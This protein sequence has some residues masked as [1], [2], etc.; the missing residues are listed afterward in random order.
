[1]RPR[2][3]MLRMKAR[4][5]TLENKVSELEKNLVQKDKALKSKD[6]IIK[7]L[8][9]RITQKLIEKYGRRSE[10]FDPNQYGLFDEPLEIED[11]KAKAELPETITVPAYE[12]KKNC[13]RKPLPKHL[14]REIIKHDLTEA[15]KVCACGTDLHCIGH[16]KAEQLE[17]IP[18]RYKVL[19]HITYKYACRSCDEGVK[20]A[21]RS[22]PL[23]PKSIITPGLASYVIVAKFCDHLPLYRQEKIFKRQQI[24]IARG[25][26]GDW[27][28]K[29]SVLC[30]P[31]LTA[32]KTSIMS[33]GYVQA[34]ETP[35]QILKL[36]DKDKPSKAY[37]WVARGG[38]PEKIAILYEFHPSRSGE[39]A[40]KLLTGF[41]GKLQTDAYQGYNQFQTDKDIEL[42]GCIAHARRKFM[43]I[44]KATK[45]EGLAS[46]AVN[47]I[48]KLYRVETHAR[49]E[50]LSNGLRYAL[51]QEKSK[52]ILEHLKSWLLRNKQNVPPESSIGKAIAYSL[53]HWGTL[54]KY[55]DD[56]EVEI[57]N[58]LIENAIRP[59]A[60]GRKNWLFVGNEQGAKA[61]AL[62]YSLVETCRA[63]EI[64]PY[65][66]LKY[67][68]S[69]LHN[70]DKDKPEAIKQLL[71]HYIDRELLKAAY[72]ESFCDK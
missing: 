5:K 17:Y 11:E 14:P 34:D 9:E 41:K 38:P 13:G 65:A 10:K 64:E 52:P 22:K 49:D 19:Q 7:F 30:A 6:N 26:L 45:Q 48:S 61:S 70:I 2:V 55:I 72:T 44:V 29:L 53:N 42:Y 35:V 66:Y 54:A 1:M 32:L 57:D 3:I 12:R 67:L 33:G 50:K 8:E 28:V 62:F 36:P 51:R 15:E 18:A 16:D 40:R 43:D 39:C 21:K 25:T 63:H 20:A 68:F 59:F 69:Q 47:I 37:M 27:I 60:L 23:I 56:G 24:T 31:L 71:P 46:E 58:N 4:I